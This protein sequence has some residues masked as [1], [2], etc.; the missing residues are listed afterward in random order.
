MT[1]KP[2]GGSTKDKSSS[3]QCDAGDF[4]V[5]TTESPV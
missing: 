3:G 2:D 5:H 1:E 4:I